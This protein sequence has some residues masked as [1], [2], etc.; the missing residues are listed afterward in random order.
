MRNLLTILCALSACT[1]AL[2]A[3]G[4]AVKEAHIDSK[5][6]VHIVAGDD[7]DSTIKPKKWQDGGGF[8]E[9]A[10]A[11][12]GRTV[13]WLANQMLTPLEGGTSYS[14]PV[15]LELDIWRDG[16]VMRRFST[17]AF[18][19]QNWIYLKD[20][21]EVAF[22]SAPPH[23]Q[24]F[25]D[26]TLFDVNSGKELA[27]WALDR[28]DYVAP[29]WVKQLLVDD[30]LPGPEDISNWFPNKQP[31][32]RRYCRLSRNKGSGWIVALRNELPDA[33]LD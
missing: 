11:R 20:G 29:D 13:G 24:E 4:P 23:G 1:L 32:L 33:S 6:W 26:C 27:H 5:G 28:K 12:D 22:H 31:R 25:F 2:A 3:T 19:I 15:A 30:P 8:A 9:I 21:D 14:Y 16:H 17:P 18:T 7:R 10:V